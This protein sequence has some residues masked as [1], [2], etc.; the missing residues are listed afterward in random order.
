M[1]I[2]IGEK[3]PA[4]SLLVM[5]G[6]GPEPVKSP[7]LFQ[8]RKTILFAVIGAFTDTCSAQHLP[9]YLENLEALKDKGIDQVVCMAV[10]DVFVM[11]AWA[12]AVGVDGKITM[13][14]DGN[15]DFSRAM[16]MD[17]DGKAFGIGHRSQR[18]AMLVEDG[19][20]RQLYVDEPGDFKVT[21]AEFMLQ[22]I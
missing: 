5:G 7:D 18:F 20:V 14:A 11:D 19:T 8:G 15:G 1:T 22:K 17:L 21:S 9:G 3:L 12:K 6:K 13:A 16:G 2:Q 10:N 4:A